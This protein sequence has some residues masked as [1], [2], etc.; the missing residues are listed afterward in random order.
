MKK[1]NDILNNVNIL[2]SK[3]S[4]DLLFKDI[5]FDSRHVSKDSLF[6]AVPG[7]LVDGHDY[8][9]EAIS[10]GALIIICERFPEKI[11]SGITYIKVDNSASV[12][13]L[14]SSNYFDNP[15]SEL[16]LVG[17]TGTNGK[18]T[19]ATLLYNL[20]TKLGY[21]AG[22]ISTIL[23]KIADKEIPATHTTP[24]A[25]QI[26]KMIRQ[27]VDDGC[28]YAF[29]E[30]SSHA[31]EQDRIAGLTFAGAVFT[32]ITH[33]HLDYHVTFKN[34][35]TAKKKLFDF[36]PS[37][38]FALSNTDDKNGKVILQNTRANKHTFGLKNMADFKAKIIEN[39]FSG[40]QLQINGKEVHTLLSG[41]FNAYNLL[42]TFATASLLNQNQEEILTA[43]SQISG[44][45]G[46]FELIRSKNNITGIVDYAHTPD[47]L[48]NV[49]SS[50]N[51]LRTRNE[52][53][54]TVVGCR[55]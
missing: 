54:I 36:L 16:K 18:T 53:L 46:R 11:E 20:F 45:E 55:W 12:L 21:K 23:N 49:L 37:S 15:S 27:M 50:I 29:M 28:D 40:M 6:V 9:E 14:I 39:H 10:K 43:L 52:Q 22:L 5:S 4:L 30:V 2:E 19:T 13:G 7:T 35:L 44:A 48:E 26:Q 51:S 41:N 25:I 32:N 17:I 31:I 1:L 3:G 47:A 33:D 8:T 34:Y 42:A 24:D 38:A